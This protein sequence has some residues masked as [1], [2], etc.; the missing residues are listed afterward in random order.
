M[1]QLKF[2]AKVRL[3]RVLSYKIN[4]KDFRAIG[5]RGLNGVHTIGF[6]YQRKYILTL[7]Q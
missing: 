5:G 1:I 2:N 3:N 7:F 4:L 6:V